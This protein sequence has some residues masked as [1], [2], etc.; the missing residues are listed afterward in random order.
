[1][2]AVSDLVNGWPGGI[3]QANRHSLFVSPLYRVVKLYNERRGDEQLAAT[4]EGRTFDT[5][6]EGKNVPALDVAASRTADGRKIFIKL[7]NTDRQNS[8]ATTIEVAG[9]R[10]AGA[11]LLETI[12]THT[13]ARMNSFQTPNAIDVRG[14]QLNVGAGSFTVLLPKQSVSVITLSVR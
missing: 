2:S 8:L 7:V 6:R 9:A 4:V 10:V 14:R 12:T 3:I 11:G 1:M 13:P 5:T